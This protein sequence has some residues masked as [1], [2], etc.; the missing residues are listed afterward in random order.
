MADTHLNGDGLREI[1]ECLH[2][3]A[4]QIDSR[5]ARREAAHNIPV[6][7]EK[8]HQL[9]RWVDGLGAPKLLQFFCGVHRFKSGVPGKGIGPHA[10]RDEL[11]KRD[12]SG[13][14]QADRE[15][16]LEKRETGRAP[17]L[18]VHVGCDGM[19]PEIRANFAEKP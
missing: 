14:E 12:E 19:Q 8:L 13:G 18:D 11:C 10:D 4:P 16:R 17:R 9:G 5:G 3:P 2:R 7:I 1:G 15:D 6:A